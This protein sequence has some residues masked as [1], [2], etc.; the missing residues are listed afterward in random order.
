MIGRL[1]LQRSEAGDAEILTG[2]ETRD[3]QGRA[4]DS[5]L[6]RGVLKE[7]PPATEWPPCA[8]CTCGAD[9]RTIQ[10]IGSQAVAACPFDARSDEQLEAQDL[11]SYEIH[12]PSLLGVLTKD[13][14]LVGEPV[15]IAVPALW[16]LGRLPEPR[17][18]VHLLRSADTKLLSAVIAALKV[19][20]APAGPFLLLPSCRDPSVDTRLAEANIPYASAPDM[21]VSA[22]RN[23]LLHIPTQRFITAVGTRSP[24][25]RKADSSVRFGD[26]SIVLTQQ[27]FKLMHLLA[28]AAE[29]NAAFVD[30]RVI[31]K[32]MWGAATSQQVADA[33]RRLRQSLVG[34]LGDD[35]TDQ[36][37]QNKSRG[38]YRINPEF[39]PTIVDD[40]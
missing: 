35:A 10:L 40:D 29:R 11:R 22:P 16:R 34:L 30:N 24:I 20:N 12:F 17:I 8:N 37:I 21:I 36:I 9:A 14:G 23:R 28:K 26:R 25:V 15:E 7:L 27:S 18:E 5:L 3:H 39:R 4:F 6:R 1:L 33:I 31:Q 13:S 38:S 19:V 32:E 2:R